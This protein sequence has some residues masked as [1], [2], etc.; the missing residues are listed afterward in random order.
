MPSLIALVLLVLIPPLGCAT[1]PAPGDRPLPEAR[2]ADFTLG[3]TVLGPDRGVQRA[4][5]TPARYLIGADGWM[6]V[7]VGPGARES[8]HPSLTRKLTGQERDLLWGLTRATGI[9]TVG[10][11]LRIQSPEAFDAPAGRRV[12]LVQLRADGRRISLAMPE[13]ETGTEPFAALGDRLAQ[14][15]WIQPPSKP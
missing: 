10:P 4:G 6:R 3:L 1:T 13:G 2:P 12:Y 7:A 8:V 14:W 9:E 15:S 11:P 5:Q